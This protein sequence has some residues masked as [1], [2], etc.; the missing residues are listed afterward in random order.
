MS[1]LDETT[2]RQRLAADPRASAWVAANAGS[3]KTYVLARRVVRLLLAGSDPGRILCLTF[4]KAAAAEMANRVFAILAEWATLPT[5]DLAPALEKLTGVAPSQGELARAPTLFATALETPGGLK[6]QTIHAFCEATLHRFPLEAN[7]AGH[8][9]VLDSFGQDSLLQ[10]ARTRLMTRAARE[11]GGVIARAFETLLAMGGEKALQQA[12]D[13]AIHQRRRVMD[14]VDA[15]MGHDGTRDGD[16]TAALT[17]PVAAALGIAADLTREQVQSAIVASPLVPRDLVRRWADAI[18]TS[19]SDAERR[20]KPPLFECVASDQPLEDRVSAW[21]ELFLTKDGKPRSRI[22]TQKTAALLPVDFPDLAAREA[23]RILDEETRLASIAARD[24]TVAL[25]VLSRQ[26]ILDYET[27]KLNRGLL[28]FDDLIAR[29]ER[30]LA[31]SEAAA[32]VHFKLDQGIDHILVDEAQD[33]SPGQWRIID[34]LAGEFFAGKTSRA[35]TRTVFAVGDE[36]QSIYGFQGAAPAAF[37]HERRRFEALATGA[38][39]TFHLVK[40]GVS[41]RSVGDVLAAVDRVFDQPD[42]VQRIASSAEAYEPH[43]S[44]RT[45][46]PG[47]VELWPM[48]QQEKREEPAE[49]QLPLDS[50]D[51]P[52]AIATVAGRVA[53]T[54]KGFLD[55]GERLEGTGR[56]IRP[57]DCL[58]LVRKRP[59]PLVPA[60]SRALKERL[61]P[62]AGA[63]RLRLTDHIAIQDLVSLGRALVLPDD[64]LALA[65]VF[66]S[67]LIGFSA[68]H[69]HDLL[70]RL[71]RRP[72]E[73]GLEAHWR[74]LQAPEA[75]HVIERIDRWRRLAGTR[76][77]YEFY[78]HVLGPDGGR[79]RL[80]ARLGPD[81]E[82]VIDEFLALALDMERLGPPSLEA[83]LARLTAAP[84]EIKREAQSGRDEVRI[85]TVHGAKGL[86]A[87][88]VFLIDQ[89]GGPISSQQVPPLVFAPADA[90]PAVPLYSKG[91]A[92]GAPRVAA[93]MTEVK[94]QAGDEHLRLLYVA[95]TRAADR[96]YVVG[97]CGANGPHE[98]CW[99]QTIS[100]AL[101]A[102]ATKLTVIPD[103]LGDR[104]RWRDTTYAPVASKEIARAAVPD[105]PAPAWLFE[106]VK[107]VA[108]PVALAPSAAARL[109]AS[110]ADAEMLLNALDAASAPEALAARRG[111]VLHKLLELLPRLAPADRPAAA[112]ALIARGLGDA[113]EADQQALA[114]E[115]LALFDDARFAAVFAAAGRS[116]VSVV[117][118][119]DRP[120]GPP[121]VVSGRID[122]L[123]VTPQSI[124]IVDYKTNRVAP[125]DLAEVSVDYVAQLAVYRHI[126]RHAWPGRAIGAA[127]LYT[128]APR[129]IEVSDAAMDAAMATILASDAA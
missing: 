5:I 84:P 97:V 90:G 43:T 115:T 2:R 34:A 52:S 79:S 33:T 59:G 71:G 67:P 93:A 51:R 35:T 8:F 82:D 21:R 22:V 74:A 70:Y 20:D 36:K 13:T 125:R 7:I 37:D 87:P 129:L 68:D 108:A 61:V 29:T 86:E 127:L 39:E 111:R 107:P 40:L 9:E 64:D 12:L 106:R 63:D 31:D 94:D 16:L 57:G 119:I 38:G 124:L 91:A 69:A 98:A 10:A 89:G 53:D 54:I 66:V 17:P 26:L 80:L 123:A 24:A 99:H 25:L 45:G 104:Q 6:I 11:P 103:P 114:A 77:P 126:L 122:R 32:W 85:M 18:N 56:R 62:V 83:F 3:G 92:S 48:V 105:V 58:I 88:I 23:A 116:E 76:S 110:E 73:L 120:R 96:L 15:W 47:F 112:A 28:D 41:F 75:R 72:P 121:L 60:L 1:S 4:T 78:A 46:E 27:A 102:D 42:I 81:A 44:N 49:W 55:S 95:M 118:R 113:P 128:A 117:G 109:G 19:G 50:E 65:E 14:A 101:L 100:N 30:L